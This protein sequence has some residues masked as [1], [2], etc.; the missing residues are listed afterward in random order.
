MINGILF[1]F[2][3]PSLETMASM[4]L[5][6]VRMYTSVAFIIPLRGEETEPVLLLGCGWRDRWMEVQYI[7]YS[8]GCLF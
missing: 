8:V 1:S 3:I 7:V 5:Y 2:M 6:T 4:L